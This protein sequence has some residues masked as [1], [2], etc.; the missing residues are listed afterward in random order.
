VAIRPSPAVIESFGAAGT[1]V[2]LAGGRGTA[3]RVGEHVLRPVEDGEPPLDW[4]TD[5]LGSI[6]GGDFR[7]SLPRKTLGGDFDSEGWCAW[8]F[9]DGLHEERRWH[10]IIAIGELFHHSL[11]DVPE[12]EFVARRTDHWA[13]GDRVA[14]GDVPAEQFIHVKHLPDLV[15]A[16]R[17]L[18]SPC[19]LVH[20]DLAGN[21][22]F[23]AELPP[24]IIDFSPFW[25]PP[26][27]ASAIVVAD[28]LVWEGADETLLSAVVHVPCFPQFLVRALVMRA[29][30]DRLFRQG[31]PNR[32]DHDD[33][34]LA[35]V[36]I[37]CRLAR[38]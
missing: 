1:P 19:Q 29:V 30:V 9:V 10:E 26:A 31:E 6:A 36:E 28:A 23:A 22:L 24:A 12:P 16:R 33:P 15:A 18:E 21:V 8:Q 5:V 2:P 3:W 7:V 25:R 37:A 34:F 4:Q 27:Y 11:A 13:I 35:A 14:W 38:S 17:P 32:P 20:G